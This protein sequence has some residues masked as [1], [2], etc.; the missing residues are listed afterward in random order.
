MDPPK[1]RPSGGGDPLTPILTF[2]MPGSVGI[3]GQGQVYP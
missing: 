2:G 3:K 1:G